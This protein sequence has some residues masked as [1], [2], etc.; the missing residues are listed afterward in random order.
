MNSFR[1]KYLALLLI[2][3]AGCCFSLPSE[4]NKSSKMAYIAGGEFTPL[5]KLNNGG[6][7]VIVK[8]FYMDV[9]P[10]T[11][12]QFLEFVKKNPQWRRSRVK[13][14]FADHF[15]LKDWQNDTTLGIKV[16]GNSP[17]TFI[18]WFAANAYAKWAGKRLPTVNEWEFAA[19]AGKNKPYAADDAEFNKKII[20]WYAKSNG[21]KLAEVGSAG[22]NYW[23]V[24]DMLGLVWEWTYDFNSAL[25]TGDSRNDSGTESNTFCGGGSAN[26]TDVK[27]YAAFMRYG[28]R[29]SLKANY[30]I[31]NLGFRCVKDIR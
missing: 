28:F 27:N 9:Y 4:K 24:Y 2:V 30:T 26:A 20:E 11:N 12:N 23:G 14:I 18:S 29:S 31:Q 13:Q 3:T 19:A 8:P 21:N 1:I 22:S 15:Y 7:N 17:V 6:S 25:L 16:N 5:Y 10:V